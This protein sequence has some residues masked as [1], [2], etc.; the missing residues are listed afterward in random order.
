MKAIPR[1]LIIPGHPDFEKLNDIGLEVVRRAG[2]TIGLIQWFPKMLR[3]AVDEVV[4]TPRTRRRSYDELEKTEKTYLGTKIEIL[5]RAKLDLP[6]GRL[7]FVIR[8]CDVDLKFTIGGNWMIPTEAVGH[9]CLLAAIDEPKSQCFLGLIVAH[10]A[11]LTSGANRDA[12]RTV[13]A[14][15]FQEIHWLLNG[16]PCPQNFWRTLPSSLVDAVFTGKTGNDRIVTLF[17]GVLDRPV[18]RRIIE[19]AG[20]EQRDFMRRIRSD[21][22][23]GARDRLLQEGVL[24]LQGNYDADLIKSLGLPETSP[25]EF[26]SHRVISEAERAICASYGRSVPVALSS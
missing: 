10:P 19:E 11:N 16:V 3:D 5:T 4:D 15:G 2:G 17:S 21:A 7:D 23:R 13:A 9:V 8:N 22:K 25:S 6:K 12:K 14:T 18:A 24:L 1:S 26:I 20:G